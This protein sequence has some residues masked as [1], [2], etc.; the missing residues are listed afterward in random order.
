MEPNEDPGNYI[1]KVTRIDSRVAAVNEPVADRHF[2][3]MI[4]QRFLESYSDIKLKTYKYPEFDL[5]NTQATMKHLYLN[6]LPG[7]PDNKD[8]LSWHGHDSSIESQL[9]CHLP[10]LWKGRPLHSGCAVP[11]KVYGKGKKPG[12]GQN[13]KK[14]Q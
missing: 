13:N 10:Q 7:N 14:Q 2:T 11:S 5:A 8:C 6:R 12:T 3:D 4:V 1:M 9:R